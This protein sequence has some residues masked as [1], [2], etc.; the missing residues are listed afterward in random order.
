MYPPPGTPKAVGKM[1][2]QLP[3]GGRC[4]MIPWRVAIG[5][6]NVHILSQQWVKTSPNR[7]VHFLR[8]WNVE[9][10]QRNSEVGPV[11]LINGGYNNPYKMALQMGA[12]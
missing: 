4:E 8:S 1:N 6:K 3:I 7:A 9:T 11:P 10:N 5:L 12:I 2:F